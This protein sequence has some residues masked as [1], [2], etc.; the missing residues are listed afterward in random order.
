[1]H[2]WRTSMAR[3][4][5][6]TG[7]M[8]HCTRAPDATSQHGPENCQAVSMGWVH[9]QSWAT[10]LVM[11]VVVCGHA[12]SQSLIVRRFALLSSSVSAMTRALQD[13]T[14]TPAEKLET[15]QASGQRSTKGEV[16][17]PRRTACKSAPVVG[18]PKESSNA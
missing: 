15:S 6:S 1:M 9:I 11:V 10:M 8:A 16:I 13:A 18:L 7:V 12:I 2:Q 3:L 14:C 4:R 5:L 17:H